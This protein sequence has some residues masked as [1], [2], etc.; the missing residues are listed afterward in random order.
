MNKELLFSGHS[1]HWAAQKFHCF[2]L[3]PILAGISLKTG[4]GSSRRKNEE[5]DTDLES[6]VH[7]RVEEKGARAAKRLKRKLPGFASRGVWFIVTVL[8]K[9][10][11]LSEGSLY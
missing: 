8:C 5:S 11:C 6:A 3:K 10:A 9:T 4:N 1:S 7:G 2:V